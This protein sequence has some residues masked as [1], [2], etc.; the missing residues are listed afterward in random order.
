MSEKK[1]LG[2]QVAVI[3]GAGSGFGREFARLGAKL[4]AKLVLAD[5]QKDA[6]DAIAAELT[7]QGVEVVALRTDVSK[8]AEVEAL[9]AA[10]ME[11]F[12]VVHLLFNNA[13]VGCGGAIWENS[14]KDWE[15]VLGVNLWGV[16]HGIRTFTPLMLKHMHEHPEYRGHIVNVASIAGLL[17]APNLGVYNVSK[18]AVVT[19]SETLFQ[20]L[21]LRS[22]RIGVSV[23]CPAFV[24]T[25][26]AH[27]QRNRPEGLKNEA[28]PT[29]SQ[30]AAQ[31]MTAKAVES[32]L[33][34][35]AEIAEMTFAA[36]RENRFY[37][38]SHSTIMP[39]VALR[40]EDIVQARNPSD[41]FAH[42]PELK[43]KL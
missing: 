23:L 3:T 5:V 9:A 13:G 40:L 4:G 34:S 37:I 22:A 17:S 29:P 35:A 7:G 33:I 43:P 30:L 31:A 41:P 8:G 2:G 24:P 28:P 16:I 20:D 15:W 6:L 19:L 39:A 18:H 32:G 42:K 21:R 38:F 25:G 12:G 11:R 27:S 1:E 10:A 26:I 36:I 14:V